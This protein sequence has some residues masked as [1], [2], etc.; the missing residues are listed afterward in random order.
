VLY[1]LIYF[2]HLEV[3]SSIRNLREA[4]SWDEIRTK[5]AQNQNVDVLRSLVYTFARA[6]LK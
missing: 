4:P 3:L 1:I 6:L 5:Q 2:S